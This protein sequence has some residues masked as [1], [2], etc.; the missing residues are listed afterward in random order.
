MI[1]WPKLPSP[2]AAAARRSFR[3]AAPGKS[4]I[5][6]GATGPSFCRR[7]GRCKSI[8]PTPGPPGRLAG[9]SWP[10]PPRA[11]PNVT[12]ATRCREYR[13]AGYQRSR[14][15]YK[16]V[17]KLFVLCD[18]SRWFYTVFFTQN[19]EFRCQRG[20]ASA[21]FPCTRERDGPWFGVVGGFLSGNLAAA[22]IG[23]VS[24]GTTSLL[25]GMFVRGPVGLHRDGASN[26]WSCVSG[27]VPP[28][29]R[30]LAGRARRPGSGSGF[31]SW[32]PSGASC[33][34]R[35]RVSG[36]VTGSALPSGRS[37][38]QPGGR[39]G[40]CAGVRLFRGPG[41]G[42]RR[43][44]G[45]PFRVWVGVVFGRLRPRVGRAVF[46]R[47]PQGVVRYRQRRRGALKRKNPVHLRVSG[48]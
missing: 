3:A 36:S 8:M 31:Q 7:A 38:R 13:A 30:T 25:G 1:R 4:F 15:V 46:G 35:G 10:F 5:E 29:E 32:T 33:W 20:F 37:G 22:R 26:A 16:A 23:E 28:L 40:A 34:G 24:E 9:S 19:D 45:L 21:H 47:L 39:N 11:A 17:E 14:S 41:S 18:I 44:V 2:G 6:S 48:A 42:G 27:E 12:A 43:S